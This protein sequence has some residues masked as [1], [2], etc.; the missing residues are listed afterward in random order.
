MPS[1]KGT[2]INKEL[3]TTLLASSQK[4]A[5]I[6]KGS[7]PGTQ[8]KGMNT[9]QTLPPKP[10]MFE[11]RK[12]TKLTWSQGKIAHTAIQ[13]LLSS[14]TELLHTSNVDASPINVEK[15]PHSL[16]ILFPTPQSN[17]FSSIAMI[18]NIAFLNSPSLQIREEPTLQ[19]LKSPSTEFS[20]LD[21][22]NTDS[23]TIEKS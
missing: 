17:I 5:N 21:L 12:K 13:P 1:Q 8:N 22:L 9:S 18:E 11:R 2:E 23:P 7:Q 15:Q 6:E 10:K 19:T 20:F 14:V 4:V 3:N 16:S